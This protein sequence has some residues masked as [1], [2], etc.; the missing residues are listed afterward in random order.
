MEQPLPEDEA[1]KFGIQYDPPSLVYVYRDKYTKKLTR[2]MMPVRNFTTDSD[3]KSVAIDI[4]ERHKEKLKPIALDKI[5]IALRLLI[6]HLKSNTENKNIRNRRLF[7][8]GP[9]IKTPENPSFRRVKM[10]GNSDSFS[11][12][13]TD[14]QEENDITS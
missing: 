7:H 3:Y 5:Q 9:K 1:Y 12:F 4:K 11:E 10:N 13:T 6:N 8:V 2:Y 14:S